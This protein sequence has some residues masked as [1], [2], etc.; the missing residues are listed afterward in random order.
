MNLNRTPE[1]SLDTVKTCLKSVIKAERNSGLI[2]PW[3]LGTLITISGILI[4]LP[5]GF[6]G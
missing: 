2:F 1:E 4:L 3:P 6:A 5:N